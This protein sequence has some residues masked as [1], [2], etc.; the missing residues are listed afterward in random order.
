MRKEAGTSKGSGFLPDIA[1]EDRLPKIHSTD[2]VKLMFP[3]LVKGSDKV[4]KLSV[5]AAPRDLII[6]V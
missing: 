6:P 4:I 5:V 1:Y 3:S 2:R